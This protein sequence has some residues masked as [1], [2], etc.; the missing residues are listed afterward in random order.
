MYS[1]PLHAV[2]IEGHANIAR[3]V[4]RCE[5]ILFLQSSALVFFSSWGISTVAQTTGKCGA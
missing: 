2:L 1:R 5:C 3:P 4:G